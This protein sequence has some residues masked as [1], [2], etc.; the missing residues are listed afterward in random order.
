MV[1]YF[2]M[3]ISLARYSPDGIPD[4]SFGSSGITMDET[5]SDITNNDIRY[6]AL[7]TDGRIIVAGGIA[8][9]NR[10]TSKLALLRFTS[11]GE[12][13]SSFGI[14]GKSISDR[15]GVIKFVRCLPNN[16]I[17]TLEELDDSVTRNP[18]NYCISR[19]N[20][21][22]SID[23]TFGEGGSTNLVKDYA[24]GSTLTSLAVLPNGELIAV[25]EPPYLSATS[26]LVVHYTADGIYEP[27]YALSDLVPPPSTFVPSDNSF[28]IQPDGKIVIGGEWQSNDVTIPKF[29]FGLKR[30]NI[31]GTLDETFK[32]QPAMVTSTNSGDD[33]A[34]TVS[35]QSNGAILL[36]GNSDAATK[37]LIATMYD[38]NGMIYAALSGNWELFTSPP[39]DGFNAYASAID[40]K[41]GNLLAGDIFVP[42]E[43]KVKFGLLCGP[44][45]IN[46]SYTF[47]S[48]DFGGGENR[49]KALLLQPDG[50]VFMAG[51]AFTGRN[52]D[53]ALMRY[54]VETDN[55]DSTF[56]SHGQVTTDLQSNQDYAYASALQPDGKIILAGTSQN[57]KQREIALVRYNSDGSLD[58]SFGR[59]GIVLT[60]IGDSDDCAKAVQV[61]KD[62]KI[63]VAGFTHAVNRYDVALVRYNSDGSLD[64]TFGKSG[65]VETSTGAGDAQANGMVI[66]SNGKIVIAGYA[67]NGKDDDFMVAC[68]YNN[69]SLDSKFGTGGITTTDYGFGDDHAN[70]LA[71]QSDGSIVVAGYAYN[72]TDKDYAVAR[73]LP[74]LS[75][76][77][78]DKKISPQDFVTIYPNPLHS[79]ATLQYELTQAQPVSI[80]LFDLLGNE[81]AVFL[82]NEMRSEGKN[83]EK[84]HFP[85]GLPSG[86]YYMVVETKEQK[87]TVRIIKD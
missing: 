66:Q 53:F 69:G 56:G 36:G 82:T 50:F 63:V 3:Y 27:G 5:G 61:Q 52:Y 74:D 4:L 6:V 75:L 39:Y 25:G 47:A 84:I 19:Y 16:K 2:Y 33:A 14:F 85:N 57:D 26:F 43:Q 86:S 18:I 79:S 54:N 68:Y 60:A 40:P 76:G 67:S 41:K 23:L 46:Y 35:L 37:G 83:S 30:F 44:N 32:S 45:P 55:I 29:I 49:C 31:D 58:N 72:G 13:D 78:I 21:D 80:K 42:E 12:P 34:N 15:H 77:V 17:I 11:D 59:S 73:Y 1:Q 70:A 22:G 64:S 7:Q 81:R 20:N 87:S 65:I 51:Y 10:G 9:D 62:G 24:K 71:L 28:L 48:F 38:R 8:I